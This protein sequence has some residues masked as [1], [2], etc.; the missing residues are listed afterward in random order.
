MGLDAARLPTGIA[1]KMDCFIVGPLLVLLTYP[2]II[3]PALLA[4]LARYCPYPRKAT[5]PGDEPPTVAMAVCALNE[6]EVIRDKIENC[7]A[8][9]YRKDKLSLVFVSDGSEDKT[10]EI[11]RPY[12]SEGIELVERETRIGKPANLNRVL[13]DRTEDI[14]VLSD[15]NVLYEPDALDRLVERFADPSVG[16]VS[17]RV[18][19]TDTTQRLDQAEKHYYSLEWKLQSRAAEFYSMAGADGA[20]YAVRREMFRACPDDT[21]IDDFVIAVGVVRSGKRVVFEPAAIGWE[22]G[23]SSLKEEF[24]RKVRIAAG[25]AQS[26]LRGNGLPFGSTARMWFVFLSH[27]LLRW[28]SPFLL[29]LTILVAALTWWCPLSITTLMAVVLLL[30]AAALK[31]VFGL[32]HPLI[33]AAF[34]FVFAQ[35]STGLGLVKGIA[36]TQSVLW[37][38]ANR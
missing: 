34:Y 18:F 28:L 14:F 6:Q 3:Y 12:V 9:T 16:A 29:A 23:P 8:L 24:R 25:A 31:L 5:E 30:A 37:E 11:I 19:L 2:F 36:G 13:Q 4:V 38:K 21:L 1:Y 27:K 26:V 20:M 17:G 10:A 15:A 7:L 35:V 22:K 33:N 32:S